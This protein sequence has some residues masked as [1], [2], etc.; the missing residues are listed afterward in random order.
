M[1]KKTFQFFLSLL[2]SHLHLLIF[3]WMFIIFTMILTVNSLAPSL[4]DYH[5][6]VF[7][8][9]Q[10]LSL[11]LLS[12]GTSKIFCSFFI[13]FFSNSFS[14]LH[15][16]LF[17]QQYLTNKKLKHNNTVSMTLRHC[18]ESTTEM[19]N[20]VGWIWNTEVPLMLKLELVKLISRIYKLGRKQKYQTSDMY[21]KIW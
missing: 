15:L 6:I 18:S 10:T 17:L 4:F 21:I 2:N 12:L 5:C 7:L 8:I 20:W 9:H 16:F 11:P 1:Q 14:W 13:F 3:L 19:R